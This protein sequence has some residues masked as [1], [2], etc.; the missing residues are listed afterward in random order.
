MKT[1][2]F[3]HAIPILR[4]LHSKPML[5]TA[6]IPHPPH[7]PPFLLHIHTPHTS[8]SPLTPTT[9]S[10]FPLPS[11]YLSWTQPM[12]SGT[13]GVL[14]VLIVPA[15]VCGA[16]WWDIVGGRFQQCLTEFLMLAEK[17]DDENLHFPYAIQHLRAW[18]NGKTLMCSLRL[19]D[20]F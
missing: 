11:M 17:K 2:H 6:Y 10:S 13:P 14:S 8:H 1:A 9:P 7:N 4:T 19:R 3:P 15:V 18:T 16:V 20:S 12:L 5:T